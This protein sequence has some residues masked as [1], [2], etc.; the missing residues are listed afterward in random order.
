MTN[1]EITLLLRSKTALVRLS[2][3]EVQSVLTY[4]ESIGFTS[5][6]LTP[7]AAPVVAAPAATNPSTSTAA[8]TS[9]TVAPPSA[10]AAAPAPAIPAA[11]SNAAQTESTVAS[12]EAIIKKDVEAFLHPAASA[13][14]AVTK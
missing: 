10:P 6:I 14:P 3:S 9:Q 12:L 2:E 1:A 11:S 13:A 5:P 4:L 7:T 8:P